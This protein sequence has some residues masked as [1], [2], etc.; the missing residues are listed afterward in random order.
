MN[1]DKLIAYKDLVVA[2]FMGVIFDDDQNEWYDSE[3]GLFVG[4]CLNYKDSWNSLMPVVE[5]IESLGYRIVIAENQT[6]VYK[7]Y[8]NVIPTVECNTKIQ[9]V[10]EAC[11]L[12]INIIK[13]S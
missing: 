7:D 8:V 3:E 11:L 10:Y 12:I 6:D 4:I 13:N 5:K 2:E 9:A 1:T